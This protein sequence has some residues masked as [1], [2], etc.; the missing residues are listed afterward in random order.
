MLSNGGKKS[1]SLKTTE[2]GGIT[3]HQLKLSK[4]IYF[5]F[6][7]PDSHY[8]NWS[9]FSFLMKDK[10]FNVITAVYLVAFRKVSEDIWNET[11]IKY[12]EH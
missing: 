4:A 6:L 9:K 7:D 10:E 1:I 5:I 12:R 2:S 8:Y 3:L 11:T